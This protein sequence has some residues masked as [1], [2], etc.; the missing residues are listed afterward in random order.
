MTHSLNNLFKA[1]FMGVFNDNLL[2][3][4]I[5][6]ISIYWAP[7]EN[8]ALIISAASITMVMPYIFLSPLAGSLAQKYSNARIFQLA[9][10]F[11]IPIML[12]AFLGFI[13]NNVFIVLITMLLM[14]IQSSLY[15]PAK[16]GLIK[17]ISNG[18][19]LSKQIGRAHV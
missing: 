19:E 15:S 13:N 12:L 1:Q 14:G 17:E 7:T 9:K 6:F 10:L 4:L 5:C 2:K 8:K 18:E 11:E 3:N 16:Y